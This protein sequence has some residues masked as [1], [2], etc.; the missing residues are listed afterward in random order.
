M[1]EIL[2]ALT[3]LLLT[4][5]R[6][7]AEYIT[8]VHVLD[9][10]TKDNLVDIQTFPA[11]VIIPS[12]DWIVQGP[13]ANTNTYHYEVNFW[14]VAR[15]A[16]ILAYIVPAIEGE[17]ENKTIYVIARKLNE[18]LYA[19]KKLVASGTEKTFEMIDRFDTAEQQVGNLSAMR[20]SVEYTVL[21][22]YTGMQ[23]EQSSLELSAF[24]FS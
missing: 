3:Q 18:I 19:N 16:D 4:E 12:R 13:F 20:V 2:A 9:S 17:P 23:N 6:D 7:N 11:V 1:D 5:L 22:V 15:S 24:S 21:K 8:S 10:I 14:I